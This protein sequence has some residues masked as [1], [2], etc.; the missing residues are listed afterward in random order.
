[1]N[2][3]KIPGCTPV[4]LLASA[5]YQNKHFTD[6]HFVFQIKLLLPMTLCLVAATAQITEDFCPTVCENPRQVKC[7]GPSSPS[8][9]RS[10]Q[11]FKENGAFCGCCNACYTVLS[12]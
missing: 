3:Q 1:M 12:K 4:S 5:L 10:G 9:C 8:D 6:K 2:F 7:P 11:V